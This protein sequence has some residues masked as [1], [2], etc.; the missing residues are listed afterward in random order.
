MPFVKTSHR[1]EV[2]STIA[3]ILQDRRLRLRRAAT[4][5]QVKF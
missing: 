3:R 1:N 2:S 4:I 5:D